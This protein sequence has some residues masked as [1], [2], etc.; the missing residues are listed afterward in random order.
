MVF[1]LTGCDAGMD[2][3]DEDDNGYI[4]ETEF[5][6]TFSRVNYYDGWDTDDDGYLN[7]R[8]LNEGVYGALD[9][10][11]NNVLDENEWDAYSSIYSE[12]RATE[13]GDFDS[14]DMDN[15]GYLASDEFMSKNG[16]IFRYSDWDQSGDDRLDKTEFN[17]GSFALWDADGDSQIN[18]EEFGLWEKNFIS[19]DKM[20]MAEDDD[21]Y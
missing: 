20:S 4:D 21:G 7:E 8:E 9:E 6:S 19:E 16:E 14:W 5:E 2:D 18:D 17:Q 1:G 12:T 15:D 13:I 11:N 3:W 10:D